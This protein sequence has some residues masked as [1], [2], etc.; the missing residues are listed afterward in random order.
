[1]T[2]QERMKTAKDL[3]GILA[4]G[5]DLHVEA[6]GPDSS[7]AIRNSSSGQYHIDP[8]LGGSVSYIVRD[9]EIFEVV[10]NGTGVSA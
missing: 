2:P 3:A 4:R 10:V 7:H 9:G 8:R 5:Y 6:H 1:M